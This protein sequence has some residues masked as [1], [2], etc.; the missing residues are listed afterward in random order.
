[1][2]AC[3]RSSAESSRT[4][5]KNNITLPEL[6]VLHLPLLSSPSWRSRTA[7]RAP[8]TQCKLHP[9]LLFSHPGLQ[10]LLHYLIG[11][12]LLLIASIVIASKSYNQSGLVAGAVRCF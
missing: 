6:Q 1:M 8:P 4:G 11:T 10:E 2:Y 12:L 7:E 5:K 3:V 9:H